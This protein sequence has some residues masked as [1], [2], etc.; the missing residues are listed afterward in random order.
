MSRMTTIK[1]APPTPMPQ[2]PVKKMR[3]MFVPV[4]PL[5]YLPTIRP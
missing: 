3:A 1:A 2:Q 4:R 5:D